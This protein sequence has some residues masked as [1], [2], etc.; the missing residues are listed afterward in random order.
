MPRPRNM[1]WSPLCACARQRAAR[2][3]DGTPGHGIEAGPARQHAPARLV[4]GAPG[5]PGACLS[6]HGLRRDRRP[7]S[8]SGA[9]GL[10]RCLAA[11]SGPLAV[12]TQ[13]PGEPAPARTAQDA[14]PERP[15]PPGTF[16]GELRPRASLL[17]PRRPS[18][19]AHV[20]CRAPGWGLGRPRGPPPAGGAPRRAVTAPHPTRHRGPGEPAPQRLLCRDRRPARLRPKRARGV[21]RRGCGRLGLAGRPRTAAPAR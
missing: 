6:G 7:P 17:A 16:G 19:S 10:A 18:R 1:T 9:G 4:C 14:R 13:R 21:L 5:A 3:V 20:Q 15:A 11:R 8:R 2:R 12:S